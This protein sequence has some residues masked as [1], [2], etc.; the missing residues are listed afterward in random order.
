MSGKV[1]FIFFKLVVKKLGLILSLS[2]Y[3]LPG[4]GAAFAAPVILLRPWNN[5]GSTVPVRLHCHQAID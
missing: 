1:F 4:A 3:A 5:K 2:L